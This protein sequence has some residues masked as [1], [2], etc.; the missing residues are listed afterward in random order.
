MTL[1]HRTKDR[2]QS[3]HE[4]TETQG[5]KDEDHADHPGK[6]GRNGGC[7]MTVRNPRHTR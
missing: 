5:V 6:H 1:R 4:E 7:E 2:G 3:G